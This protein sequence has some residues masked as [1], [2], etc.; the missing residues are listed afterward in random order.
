MAGRATFV[1]R[2][3]F[4]EHLHVLRTMRVV[5]RR[6]LHLSFTNRHVGH[7][8]EFGNLRFMALHARLGLIHLLELRNFR[9]RFVHAM[10][11][12]ARD[13]SRIVFAARP[14]VVFASRVARRAEFTDLARFQLRGIRDRTVAISVHVLLA[15]PMAAF[16]CLCSRGRARVFRTPVRTGAIPLALILVAIEALLFTDVSIRR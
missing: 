4:P 3:A 2:I 16:T 11:G 10:A 13:V 14:L 1:D 9:F 8:M 6:A 5:A 15:R 12:R 7:T